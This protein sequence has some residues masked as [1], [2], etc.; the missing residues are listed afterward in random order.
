MFRR[1]FI[2]N[3]VVLALF[4]ITSVLMLTFLSLKK[5]QVAM[6]YGFVAIIGFGS[7][8]L[9]SLRISKEI[10]S[11]LEEISMGLQRVGLGEDRQKILS[12]E[13]GA[14]GN[15]VKSFNRMA[16]RLAEK[17]SQLEEDR[18]QLRTILSGMVEGVVALDS[19]QR[20]LFANE[21]ALKLLGLTNT[22]T[23]GKRLWE[24]IRNRDLM[25][26]VSDSLAQPDPKKKELAWSLGAAKNLTIH[27]ARLP[28]VPV[29]GAVLVLH[30]TTELRRLERL[31]QDFVANVSHELKTPL[32][33]IK[34]CAETLADGAMDDS[35]NRM[36]FLNQILDQSERLNTLIMDLLSLARIEAETE[37]FEKVAIPV[38]E[39]VNHSV[40]SHQDITKSKSQILVSQPMTG[41]FAPEEGMAAWCDEEAFLQI[42]DNLLDNAVRYTP[43]GGKIEVNWGRGK[44]FVI[45]EVRD[46]GVG[47]P[48]ADLPR[49]FERFYRVDKARSKQLGGT[50]LGLSIVKHLAQAMNGTITATSQVGKGTSFTLQLPVYKQQQFV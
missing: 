38:G 33:V 11:L 15:L 36:R 41:D 18:Q 27:A 44:D 39:M 14:L 17:I 37:M 24:L 7:L 8:S 46:N 12:D 26:L 43:D 47:I 45:I 28:G 1:L 20:I 22:T 2:P 5:S 30:D 10:S 6:L 4:L 9:V 49:I 23:E 50:G 3:A 25:D 29:R 19:T 34:V 13:P 21:T 35:V 42:L 32:A 40:A 31:R 16:I 48:E